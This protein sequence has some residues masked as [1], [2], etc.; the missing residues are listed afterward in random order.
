[1]LTLAAWGR[2]VWEH[3]GLGKA[4]A[5]TAEVI[6]LEGKGGAAYGCN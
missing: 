4:Q 2:V 6:I 3:K 5:I 1:M